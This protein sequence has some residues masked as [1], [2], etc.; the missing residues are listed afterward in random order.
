MLSTN[1]GIKG[2]FFEAFLLTYNRSEFLK[3][4]L[5]SLVNQTVDFPITI[6]DN[7]ST[8]KTAEVVRKI[9][10]KFPL[11]IIKFLT[12]SENQGAVAN[13]KRAQEMA[14]A[15]YCI[16]FH[17]D[18]V[19]HPNYIKTVLEILDK[20]QDIDI[21]S[22]NGISTMNPEIRK[23]RKMTGKYF[24]LSKEDFAGYLTCYKTFNYP[25]TIYK[26]SRLKRVNHHVELYGKISDRPYLID[27]VSETGKA[28]VLQDSYIKYRIH[29]GQDSN[30]DKTG[31]FE[32]EIL[33]VLKKYNDETLGFSDRKIYPFF[34]YEKMWMFYRWIIRKYMSF[35]EFEQKCLDGGI[36]EKK[37][38][39]FQKR[40]FCYKIRKILYQCK[41]DFYFKK[42]E[43][44][45]I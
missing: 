41:R 9:Q 2:V 11:K 13:F 7:A 18:D 15:D 32:I 3:E 23:W 42:Y 26:T 19:L 30:T 36:L 24:L 27:I 37:S 38:P 45:V 4:A 29:A 8:D 34:M 17:D 12:V 40:N 22:C 31:P 44:K 39:C 1:K 28:I 43:R 20:N 6:L 14:T 21:L 10:E 35:E 33:H 25:A 5:L 16:L